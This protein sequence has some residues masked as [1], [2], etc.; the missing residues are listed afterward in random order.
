M[1][2]L[3]RTVDGPADAPV[4]VFLHSLGSDSSMWRPQ[5]EAL[6]TTHRVVR[7]DTRGHGRSHTPPGPYAV[8]DLG[9]DV[10]AV[11][12]AEGLERFHLVGLS[13]GG[14]TALWLAIHHG[15][16]L[17]SLTA[18]NTAARVADATFWQ[19]RAQAV[20]EQGLEG[21]RDA[22]V[23]RFFASGF[24]EARPD[25]FAE[26]RAAFVGGDP[27]GYIG[28]CG[29]LEAA[30]LRDAVEAIGVPT[31][32][33]GGDQ[34]VATPPGDALWLQSH[35]G[36]SHLAVLPRAAH[37]SNLDQPDLFTQ[38]LRSHLEESG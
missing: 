4:V 27:N 17:R 20:R 22:V 31:L 26:A 38:V 10:L 18:A 1:N 23:G 33:V 2:A 14:L 13:L 35:I 6:A 29:A 21:I 24:A 7:V 28:C 37:L 12:D 15:D 9:R 8:D 19:T 11:A 5:A 16:R 3:A 36:G 34:D 25:W 30:D 32:V